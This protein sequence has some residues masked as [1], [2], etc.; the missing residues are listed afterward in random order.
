MP[1]IP[2][3]TAYPG[4]EFLPRSRNWWAWLKGS[5]PECI[6]LDHH[7]DFV[8]T[9]LPDTLY[10]RGKRALRRDPPRPEV[11]LCRSCLA[12]T[13]TSEIAAYGGRVAAFEPNA[14]IFTQ[15]FFVAEAD[16]EAAGLSPEVAD[17]VK[18][19]LGQDLGKCAHCSRAA[20]WLWFSRQQVISLD[21]IEQILDAS[22]EALCGEHGA[23]K[24]WTTF[25]GIPEA[26][27]FYMNLPYGE[28]GAYVWI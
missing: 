17:A 20:Q 15:Y 2:Y 27:L 25:A 14:E 26:N 9:V 24:L 10:L 8:A 19:R 4:I 13:F 21:E 11:S 1:Q 18:T 6:H 7:A 12:E 28:S 23:S 22:G 5:S 16:F 3:E